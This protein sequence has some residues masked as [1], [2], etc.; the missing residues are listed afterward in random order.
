MKR[1]QIYSVCSGEF[2]FLCCIINT[3]QL[4]D[5][6]KYQ[7]L[8][9]SVQS[10]QGL[11]YVLPYL[12]GQV[13]LSIFYCWLAHT[14]LSTFETFMSLFLFLS[15]NFLATKYPSFC[16]PPKAQNSLRFIQI[17]GK[18]YKKPALTFW[19]HQGQSSKNT[20]STLQKRQRNIQ[21]YDL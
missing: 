9:A 3:D 18:K 14:K 12:A 15:V 11:V 5:K 16:L 19:I 10:A 21:I 7:S 2:I 6:V 4:G 17:K 13:K 1:I 20:S 8:S